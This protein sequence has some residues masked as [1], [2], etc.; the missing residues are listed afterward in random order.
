MKIDNKKELNNALIKHY[1]CFDSERF[2]LDDFKPKDKFVS[3]VTSSIADDCPE[4]LC[5]NIAK[6]IKKISVA[7]EFPFIY[8]GAWAFETSKL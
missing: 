8:V 1:K 7:C 2:Y 3:V 6:F 5:R 4:N